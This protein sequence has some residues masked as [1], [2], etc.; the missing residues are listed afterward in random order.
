MVFG[1]AGGFGASVALSGLDGSNGFKLSG[2]ADN[3]YAGRS[4]SAAGDV[5]GDGFDDL[6]IG[7]FRADEGGTDRGAGYV[8]FGKAGGFDASV[9][10][11]TLNG[12]NGFKLSGVAD[13]DRAGRSVSAAGDVNGDG[14]ADLLIGAYAADEGGTDRGAAYVIFGKAGGFG[15]SVALSSLDGSN[16]FKLSGVANGDSGGF[17]ISAAGDVNGDGFADLIIGAYNADEGG[18]NRGAGYVVFGK[19]GGF[20]ASVALSGLDGSNGFKLSGIADNDFGGT[21]VSA[22]GDV[23]GDSFA[24]LIISALRADE[25][26]T[27][28]GATYVVFGGPSGEFI[29]PTFSADFRTATWTDVDGDL[30]TLKVSKGTLDAGNFKLLA[31]STADDRAQL[32]ALNLAAEFDGAD[33]TLTA[34]RAGGGNGKVNLGHLNAFNVDLG[35]VTVSGDL[36]QIFVGDGADDPALK[37]LTLGSLGVFGGLT[38][39]TGGGVFSAVVGPVGA[40]KIAGDV[41]GAQFFAFDAATAGTGKIA[42]VTI[43]GSLIG[44]SVRFSGALAAAGSLGPV[45]IGGDLIGGSGIASGNLQAPSLTS[46]IIG[47]DLRGSASEEGGTVFIQGGAGKVTIGGSIIGGGGAA[48]GRLFISGS[49]D[50]LTIGGSLIGGGGDSS[51]EANAVGGIGNVTIGGSQIGGKGVFSG[52]LTV[53]GSIGKVVIKRDQI[54]GEGIASGLIFASN[55]GANIASV[56]IGGDARGGNAAFSGGIAAGG[57]LGPVSIKGNVI[58]TAEQ[59]YLIRGSGPLTGTKSVAI[60]SVK[61]GGDFE[62]ALILAGYGNNNTPTNGHAQIGAISVGGDWIA[63]SVTA[64]LLTRAGATDA[65]GVFGNGDDVFINAGPAGVIASIAS[66]TIKGRAVGSQETGDHFGIVAEQIGTVTVGGVKLSLT[67]GKSNDLAGIKLGT[68]PD[69]II[70]EVA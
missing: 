29:D 67:P 10:L 34:K 50:S 39:D 44:G 21:S 19:A 70:R 17:S 66:I 8:I 41:K 55:A 5:N 59:A 35:K 32:L 46:L 6:I 18:T 20:G 37:S 65:L 45:K 24:D 52:S 22:A 31:K 56:T 54:G 4:V 30:V 51:G 28:R 2:L 42:S 61:V 27:D 26:G 25:G 49:L 64:G 47:G 33:I 13:S 7:A 58:G 60:A 43:G 11:S 57:T 62:H 36:G 63:S 38:Q 14:F 16:G 9:A 23:N 68:T 12:T 15:A 3:D 1:K 53:G 40:V 48:S 69:F